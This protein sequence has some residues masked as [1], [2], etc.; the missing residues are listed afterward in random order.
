MDNFRGC[1]SLCILT[2]LMAFGKALL[3]SNIKSCRTDS[4][5]WCAVSMTD[6]KTN[7]FLAWAEAEGNVNKLVKKLQIS[8][9]FFLR[10]ICRKTSIGARP[11]LPCLTISHTFCPYT[12]IKRPIQFSRV[13]LRFSFNFLLFM[14]QV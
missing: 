5:A 7:K 4:S 8:F 12:H 6:D 9:D 11:A 14:L 3:P 10:L 13:L 1:Y 2:T